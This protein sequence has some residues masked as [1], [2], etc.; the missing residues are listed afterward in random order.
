MELRDA[1]EIIKQ[2]GLYPVIIILDAI[3]FGGKGNAAKVK[4]NLLYSKTPIANFK[5]GDQIKD[6]LQKY[7][8]QPIKSYRFFLFSV[9]VSRVC[10]IT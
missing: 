2:R 4:E 10:V 8:S 6:I 1:A 5:Y 7:L 9:L 3:S